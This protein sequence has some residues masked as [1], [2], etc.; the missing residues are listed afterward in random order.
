[1]PEEIPKQIGPIL[2]SIKNLATIN[3]DL[4]YAYRR[5]FGV[6]LIFFS[7]VI[8]VLLRIIET[9]F[10]IEFAKIYVLLAICLLSGGIL[11]IDG[12]KKASE[13]Q[14]LEK[15][16]EEQKVE[17]EKAQT[18]QAEAE[19]DILEEHRA[20]LK[21]REAASNLASSDQQELEVEKTTFES[22]DITNEQDE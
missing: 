6:R 19:A 2:D 3:E 22:T 4:S 12:E 9:I 7:L 14:K 11:Y 21:E 10:S 18:R 15:E 8:I 13:F 20:T 5:A 17:Q 1:M 16:K